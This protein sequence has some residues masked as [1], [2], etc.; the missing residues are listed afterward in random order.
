MTVPANERAF[1]SVVQPC[2]LDTAAQPQ[3][4]IEIELLGEDD[5]GIPYEAYVLRLPDGQEVEGY[6]DK[7][8]LAR[9]DG[10]ASAGNC[11]LSFPDRD[12]DAWFGLDGQDAVVMNS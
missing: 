12:K 1:D 2:P 10:I 3:H 6:L 8:G 4:W 7:E 9:L 5:K 11:L